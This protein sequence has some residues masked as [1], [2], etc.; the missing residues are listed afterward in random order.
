MVNLT[1]FTDT[2]D[3]T[4]AALALATSPPL[5]AAAV[6]IGDCLIDQSQAVVVVA[7]PATLE[8]WS[9]KVSHDVSEDL[10]VAW[11]NERR[12]CDVIDD[13][14]GEGLENWRADAD[15]GVSE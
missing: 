1:S 14:M 12:P 9:L 2:G 4:S 13:V 15:G 5:T 8:S 6:A 10:T 11:G 7:A 3:S